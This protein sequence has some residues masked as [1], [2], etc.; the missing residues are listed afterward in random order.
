[1][2]L[3]LRI[4]TVPFI[5]AILLVTY[6]IAYIK[7][8]WNW[9]RHGGEVAVYNDKVNQVTIKQVFDMADKHFTHEREQREYLDRIIEQ[10]KAQS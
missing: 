8:V 6:G 9:L 5:A 1:M 2:K 7:H 4:I 3:L 10:S